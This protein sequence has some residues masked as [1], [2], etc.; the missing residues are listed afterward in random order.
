M[1]PLPLGVD[2]Q[3]GITRD[4]SE[5]ARARDRLSESIDTSGCH[6]RRLGVASEIPELQVGF[7]PISRSRSN[8]QPLT[9]AR[10]KSHLLDHFDHQQRL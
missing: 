3:L 2:R 5:S 10:Y 7:E 6:Q 9:L 8:G 1:G 4:S